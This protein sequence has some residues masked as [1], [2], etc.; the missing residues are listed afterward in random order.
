MSDREWRKETI[1][2]GG[3]PA[4][5]N[6]VEGWVLYPEQRVAY[7][8]DSPG[9]ATAAIILTECGRALWSYYRDSLTITSQA[10]EAMRKIGERLSELAV[11][12]WDDLTAIERE[13][14]KALR[15]EA[16]D[17]I[18]GAINASS[19]EL[20]ERMSEGGKYRVVRVNLKRTSYNCAYLRVAEGASSFDVLEA[21]EVQAMGSWDED[22]SWIE[23]ECEPS[24]DEL[25]FYDFDTVEAP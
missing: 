25:V 13:P 6:E 12:P 23:G 24:V 11:K 17:K 22:D 15:N 18:F 20:L 16:R 9:G 7:Y 10:E 8:T 5:K 14:F 2:R 19:D 4:G 3:G 1:A 21:A